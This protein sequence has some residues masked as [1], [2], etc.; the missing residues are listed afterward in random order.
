MA[1][2]WLARMEAWVQGGAEIVRDHPAAWSRFLLLS[3]VLTVFP[4]PFWLMYGIAPLGLLGGLYLAGRCDG[5][6]YDWPQLRHALGVAIL[7]G[8]ILTLFGLLFEFGRETVLLGA[9]LSG[10]QDEHWQIGPEPG[11]W[12]WWMGFSER[13]TDLSLT[14]YFWFSPAFFGV[15]LALHKGHGW[16]EAEVETTLAL[17]FRQELRDPLIA[18]WA[19]LLIASVLLPLPAQVGLALLVWVLGPPIVHVAYEDIFA[20]K[21]RPRRKREG[22]AVSLPVLQVQP[23]KVRAS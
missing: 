6:V 20:N 16:I 4:L 1:K 23:Q 2:A 18:L 7:W 13:L 15:A 8:M 17:L 12:G 11:F 5:Q 3:L 14:P 10:I 9:L 19:I 21:Q 22:K